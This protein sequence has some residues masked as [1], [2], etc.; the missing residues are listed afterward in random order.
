[1]ASEAA[2]AGLSLLP[3]PGG[4]AADPEGSTDSAGDDQFFISRPSEGSRRGRRRLDIRKLGGNADHLSD[5]LS[6]LKTGRLLHDKDISPG[7]QIVP[8]S[9]VCLP[10][11]GRRAS[12]GMA[13]PA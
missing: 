8:G 2:R 1:M 4:C 11:R 3:W 10:G 9:N 7:S 13:R 5:A 12:S 6:H